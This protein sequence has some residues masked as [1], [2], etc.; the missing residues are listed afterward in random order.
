MRIEKLEIVVCETK[1]GERLVIMAVGE[2]GNA[3]QLVNDQWTALPVLPTVD[4]PA[5]AFRR[6]NG[7]IE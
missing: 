3:Y 6:V 4:T 2:D 7:H 5:P 1:H